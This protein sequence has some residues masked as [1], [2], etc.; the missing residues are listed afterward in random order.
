[1]RLEKTKHRSSVEV[2]MRKLGV[3]ATQLE[4]HACAQQPKRMR[5]ASEG[6]GVNLAIA[7]HAHRTAVCIAHATAPAT[8]QKCRLRKPCTGIVKQ[9]DDGREDTREEWGI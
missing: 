7:A 2:P 8:R 5:T 6:C 3:E 1:M 4:A 9:G